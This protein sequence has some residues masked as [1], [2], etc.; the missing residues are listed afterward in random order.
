VNVILVIRM[1]NSNYSIDVT[2]RALLSILPARIILNLREA[3]RTN[4]LNSWDVT[5]EP[6]VERSR[7]VEGSMEA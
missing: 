2:Y 7:P 1:G 5:A 3:V 6:E 4:S